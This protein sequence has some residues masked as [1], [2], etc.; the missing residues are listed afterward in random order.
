LNAEIKHTLYFRL[1]ENH[2]YKSLQHH[3]K[4]GGALGSHMRASPMERKVRKALGSKLKEIEQ[5]EK[6]GEPPLNFTRILLKF[7]TIRKVL[8]RIQ[9]VFGE[10]DRNKSG[11][12]DQ[13]ELAEALT[14]LQVKLNRQEIQSLFELS[15]LYG[16]QRLNLKEFLVALAVG[17]ILNVI[18]DLTDVMCAQHLEEVSMKVRN[19]DSESF[20]PGKEPET[21]RDYEQDAHTTPGG[22]QKSKVKRFTE[23]MGVQQRKEWRKEMFGWKSQSAAG[24]NKEGKTK[25]RRRSSNFYGLE[26]EIRYVMHVIVAAYLMFDKQGRGII[27]KKDVANAVK[28]Q[29][30]E[31]GGGGNSFLSESRWNEMD[32]DQNGFITFAD[33]VYAFTRWVDVDGDDDDEEFAR[34]SAAPQGRRRTN[35]IIKLPVTTK[36]GSRKNSQVSK[37]IPEVEQSAL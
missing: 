1:K 37:V 22:K 31:G 7:G 27:S 12:I 36:P 13:N 10:Y 19:A 2:N 35:S 14:K 23:P 15:D 5:R 34:Q 11:Y 21:S 20:H 29:G 18:P 16:T 6:D 33:F 4:M 9:K 25:R 30:K 8:K 32:W 3:Y 26:E 24:H 28:E 17:F